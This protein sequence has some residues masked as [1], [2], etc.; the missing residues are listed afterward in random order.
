[1]EN[2]IYYWDITAKYLQG[3]ASLEEHDELLQWRLSHNDHETQFKAQ[4][5]LWAL[6][7]Y[8]PNRNVNTKKAWAE[9]EFLVQA[10]LN[11]HRSISVFYPVLKVAA[12]IA[13]VWSFIWLFNNYISPYYRM[14]VV[15]AGNKRIEFI[16]PDHSRVWLNKGSELIYNK[17]FNGSERLVQLKGEGFF[18]VQR[19]VTRPFIIET[20]D[21]QTKVLGT[22]FNLRAYPEDSVIDLVVA[23]GKVSFNARSETNQ[24][25]ITPGNGARINKVNKVLN[26]YTISDENSWA[27][28]SGKL[29]FADTPLKEVL[30][31]LSRYYEIK[32][33][34]QNTGLGNCRFT[35]V[36]TN[37]KLQEVLKVLQVT[38]NLKYT[39]SDKQSI[40]ISGQGCNQ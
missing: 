19:D 32:I 18:E 2:N 35:G 28:R 33:E 12:S 6:T 4:E 27:W 10:K 3:K 13:V 30:L 29:N 21:V 8:K 22:S 37:A 5:D 34:L 38:L 11:K 17:D 15:K 16:L 25:I 1:M 23:T 26:K 14:E 40:V 7:E 9:T 36:F 39:E 20:G 24:A 31:D